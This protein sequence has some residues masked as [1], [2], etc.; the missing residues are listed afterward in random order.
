MV[1]DRPRLTER[2]S[3]ITR[4][5]PRLYEIVTCDPSDVMN[6]LLARHRRPVHLREVA[7]ARDVL[8]TQ[9]LS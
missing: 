7:L 2:L 6:G 4:N 8:L 1:R 5:C 3:E 9:R